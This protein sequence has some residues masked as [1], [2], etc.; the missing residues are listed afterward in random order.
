MG[1][2]S[3]GDLPVVLHFPLRIFKFNKGL[4]MDL[5]A[6]TCG[7]NINLVDN[8]IFYIIF[9][10]NTHIQVYYQRNAPIFELQAY[11][12]VFTLSLY[13]NNNNNNN[14]NNTI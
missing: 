5:Q 6:E 4:I 13:N 10:I 7:I 1:C 9:L 8:L 3:I 12:V 11:C 2:L 14:N